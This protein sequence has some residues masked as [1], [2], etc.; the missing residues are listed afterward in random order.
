MPM[1]QGPAIVP[2]GDLA[3]NIRSFTFHLRALN[4]SPRTAV[5]YTTAATR[6]AGFLAANRLPTRLAELRRT[7]VEAHIADLVETRSAATAAHH[8][9][10]LQQFFRWATDD[11]LIAGSPMAKMRPPRVPEKLIAVLDESQLRALVATTDGRDF[12]S[13]RDAAL[14]RVFIDTGARRGEVTNLRYN[15]GDDTENDVDLDQGALRVLGKG[16]R[17]RILPI[18]ARTVK[19]LDRY[20]RVRAEHPGAAEPWLWL[21]HKGRL[22]ATGIA[23]MLQRRGEQAGL[24]RIYPHQL[25]HS[26]AH[27]WLAS[28]GAEGDL[29]R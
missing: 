27:G 4:V 16:R 19:A 14:L 23:Q 29:M 3:D 20:G 10:S 28:G 7:D 24:G 15:P 1:A 25:R 11:E 5:I 12:E 8:Y 6:L 17:E 9:R 13:R 21:G 22:T 18:G 26:F 2:T